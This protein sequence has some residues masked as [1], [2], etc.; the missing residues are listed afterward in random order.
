MKAVYRYFPIATVLLSFVLTQSAH[1]LTVEELLT[2]LPAKD[3][4]HA[5]ELYEQIAAGDEAVINAL[6]DAVS[7]WVEGA[8]PKI[9]M[10]LHGL[11]N[12]VMRPECG[13]HRAKVARLYEAALNRTENLDN[14]RFFMEM[15]RVC[16]DT[17]TIGV[18]AEYLCNVDLYQDAIITIEAI[19]GEEAL[20]V[21]KMKRCSRMPKEHNAA[22]KTAILR[23]S[24]K[25]A[26]D[27]SRTRLDKR[28][29]E[30]VTTQPDPKNKKRVAELCRKAVAN[31]NLAPHARALALRALVNIEGTAAL[32]DLVSAGESGEPVIWG[33]ALQLSETLQGDEV[34]DAWVRRLPRLPEAVRPQVIFMLGCRNESKAKAAIRRALTDESIEMR[35]AACDAIGRCTDKME[36]SATVERTMANAQSL[37][38]IEACKTVLLQFPEPQLSETAAR[39]VGYGGAAQQVAFLEILAARHGEQ[40]IKAVRRCLNSEAPEVRLAAVKTLAVIGAP[41]DM[42]TLF[43][44]VISGSDD[45]MMDAAREALVALADRHALRPAILAQIEGVF[46][47]ADPELKRRFMKLLS[48]LGGEESLGKMRG[49]AEGALF[50]EPRDE[51]LGNAALETLGAWPEVPACDLLLDFLGKAQTAEIRSAIVKQIIIAACRVY[52]EP[53]KQVRVM[54]KARDLLTDTAEQQPLTDAIEKLKAERKK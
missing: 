25:V 52:Q 32:P 14:K 8:N 9:P 54:E 39:K 19:G 46:A 24:N 21:L 20:N 42:T 44:L 51:A 34:A 40:H 50:G 1:A 30:A 13:T 41:E 6:C 15:L 22:V 7:L 26:V 36:F 45:A 3:S 23:M 16:G 18:L 38:E 31:K 33:M 17:D 37:K 27:K 47:T 12:Y 2:Q 35:L 49:I 29:L 10:A 4:A 43:A 53:P 28:I 48:V 5:G 11:A